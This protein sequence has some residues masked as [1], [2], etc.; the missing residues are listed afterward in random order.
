MARAAALQYP[1]LPDSEIL[2]SI[3]VETGGP[4][5]GL[6]PVLA[7]GACL[8][9]NTE[10]RFYVELKPGD[11]MIETEAVSV[12]WPDTPAIET[13]ARL[14]REGLSEAEAIAAFH[15]WILAVANGRR[16]VYLAF[17]AAFD[18]A[19]T[20][21][22]FAR[23]G[24]PDPFGHAP[25]DI[26]AYWAGKLGVPLEDTR[27]SRLPDQ[28]TQGLPE[29]SHRADEDAVRQAEIFKRMRDWS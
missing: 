8:A 3:D 24:L 7:I 11:K 14:E 5:P 6:Y 18:W 19:F 28:L 25:L 2:I 26:K 1:S 9:E 22:C 15:R 16:P 13:L 29:H 21:H 20:H 27:K 10:E 23:L 17:N 12:S 4:V